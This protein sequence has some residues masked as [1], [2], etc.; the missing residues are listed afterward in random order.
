[1]ESPSGIVTL[2]TDFGVRDA[3]VGA[4]KG[5]LCAIG[6]DL[7]IVDIS[8]EV[9]PGDIVEGVY[10]LE[11][12]Y[13]WFPAGTVHLVV[14]DPGVGTKRRAIAARSR[15]HFFVGPDNGVLTSALS[16][17][18]RTAPSAADGKLP[19]APALVHEIREE[20]YLLPQ[21]SETFHGRDLFAPAAAHI[22]SGVPLERLGP[23]IDDPIVLELPAPRIL[24]G[25][26]EG[27]IIRVDRF[28]NAISNITRAMLDDLGHGP[29]DVEVEERAVGELRRMYHD[30]ASG[31]WLALIGSGG[32]LEVAARDA[33]AAARFG[34]ARGMRV[35]AAA[36]SM[37]KANG[38]STRRDGT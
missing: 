37:R 29:F 15:G 6:R 10:L 1:M 23:A 26:V 35:T 28:G 20:K 2:L 25:R 21:R 30:V 31:E 33:N 22:A 4:M 18:A 36:R 34:I 9:P 8:H 13:G 11:A 14:I 38:G 24:P 17:A 5:V 19:A 3:Y 7:R 16:R 27:E 32:Q 12:A